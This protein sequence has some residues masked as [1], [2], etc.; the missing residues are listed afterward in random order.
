MN[1][2]PTGGAEAPHFREGSRSLRVG[3]DI[4]LAAPPEAGQQRM[5]WRLGTFLGARGDD[6]H[7]L[8]IRD[9]P[10]SVALPPGT[11]LHRLG[12]LSGDRLKS[13]VNGLELDVLLLNPERS[14]RY[15]GVPANVLRAAYG[16]EHYVQNLRSF[17]DPVE[18]TVRK[19]ARLAPWTL[20]DM[21]W[22]RR[23]Y[24]ATQPPPEVI[25][26][27]RY[28]K[29]II[30]TSYSLPDHHVHILPNAIDTGE[31]NPARC[32]PLRDEM[33]AR[34]GI[35]PEAICFLFLGHNFRRKGFWQVLRALP[36]LGKTPRPVHLLVAG[37]G[38]GDSQRSKAHRLAERYGVS[39][40]VHLVGPV[41]PA[42]HALAAADALVFLSWHDAFGWVTLE[43]MGC[44]LPVVTTPYAGSS[45]LITHAE[46]GLIVDP[47]DDEAILE[48]LEALLDDSV[49]G[50]I[51]RAAA[52][53]AAEIDEPS[54]FAQFRRIMEVAARR[55]GTPIRA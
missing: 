10:E 7:F 47:A 44:G 39:N 49:R 16:T 40:R 12:H 8:T 34:W 3:I 22:E 51:G 26:Q 2:G 20:T 17:R 27:A 53:I 24:E 6:A 43:A 38:T 42:V 36:R 1:D 46:T 31:Y 41:R 35:P 18:R 11:S 9:L 5:L 48:A 45:E 19:V 33:R 50:P 29:D 28:M 37:R 23:F 55:R 30:L 4:R 21:H 13:T 32:A 52:A 25:A 15:R 54:Y 14:R